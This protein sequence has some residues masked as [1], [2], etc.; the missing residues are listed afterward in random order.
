MKLWAVDWC[1]FEHKEEVMKNGLNWELL[2]MIIMIKSI[3]FFQESGNNEDIDYWMN[4]LPRASREGAAAGR[5]WE[6]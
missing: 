6:V 2:E 4:E 3:D 1:I 5:W